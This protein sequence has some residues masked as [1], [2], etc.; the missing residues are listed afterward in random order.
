[1]GHDLAVRRPVF[2]VGADG[3][4]LV[5]AVADAVDAERPDVDVVLLPGDLRHVGGH[6]RLVRTRGGRDEENGEHKC[7]LHDVFPPHSPA[8]IPELRGCQPPGRRIRRAPIMI[9]VLPSGCA[10]VTGPAGAATG[11]AIRLLWAGKLRSA[12]GF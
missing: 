10:A 6:A 3:D 11:S 1:G 8:R 9:A 2:G 12:V 7:E 5:R 4:E